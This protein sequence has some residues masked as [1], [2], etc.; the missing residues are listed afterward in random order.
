MASRLSTR[1]VQEPQLADAFQV[2]RI[3]SSVVAPPSLHET[4]L[5]L[6]TPL[7]PQITPS[8][9]TASTAAFGLSDEP[10]PPAKALPRISATRPFH[11]TLRRFHP[12][13][14]TLPHTHSP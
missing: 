6:E 4:T 9:E 5:A 10:P 13:K 7:Q 1:P 11:N 8:S 14:T 12:T 3:A 2:A